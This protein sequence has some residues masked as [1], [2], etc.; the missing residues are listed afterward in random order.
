MKRKSVKRVLVA[1]LMAVTLMFGN[2]T[3]VAASAEITTEM[4]VSE[5]ELTGEAI[6][7]GT[8]EVTSELPED[9][10]VEQTTEMTEDDL[11]EDAGTGSDMIVVETIDYS[12][13]LQAISEQVT[14]IQ[15]TL[16]MMNEYFA[17]LAGFC[18]F[19]VIVVLCVFSYK[20]FRMF[21]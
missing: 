12:D 19:G 20:F 17:Y 14:D 13:H 7:T 5:T 18:L 11:E 2:V 6:E 1:V 8:T 9:D 10:Q 21:F 3:S 15:T 16:L 4:A